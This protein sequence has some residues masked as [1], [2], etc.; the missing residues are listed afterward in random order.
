MQNH[1]PKVWLS[2]IPHLDTFSEISR[3]NPWWKLLLGLNRMPEEFPLVK[4]GLGKLPLVFFSE[5]SLT[6]FERELE[7][8]GYNEAS[9]NGNPY[10]NLKP[11]VRFSVDYDSIQVGKFSHPKP[12]SKAFNLTWI[13]VSISVND[14]TEHRL[15]SV[16]G[17]GV[18]MREIARANEEI[19]DFL[20][21]RARLRIDGG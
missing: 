20:Q 2:S 13:K 14:Q 12:F 21:S 19:L 6:L 15:L 9:L 17:S 4:F 8:R 10:Q 18:H 5:G 1:Y 7:F 11:N 16:G 3:K